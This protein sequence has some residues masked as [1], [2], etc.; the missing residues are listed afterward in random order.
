MEKVNIESNN[1]SYIYHFYI[2][3]NTVGLCYEIDD[4]YWCS[5]HIDVGDNP[6]YLYFQ[7]KTGRNVIATVDDIVHFE[8]LLLRN[9]YL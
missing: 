2:H 8:F 1:T 6:S 4:Y 5:V 7:M 9:V 3:Y